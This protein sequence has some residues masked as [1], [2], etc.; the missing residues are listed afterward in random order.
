[1]RL[2]LTGFAPDLD[3]SIPG[4]LTD[5]DSIVPTTRG[6]AAGASLSPSGYPA[7]ASAPTSAFVAELLDGSKRTFAATATAIYEAVSGSWTDR[8]RVGGY[9]GTNRTR[10]CV[11]GNQVLSANRTQIINQAAPGGA[12]ADIAGAPSASI[13]V[14]AAG[15][16]MA[17]N[18]NGMTLGDAPDGWGCCAVRN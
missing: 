18:I 9:T 17:L 6:L 2:E 5:C 8:S 14:A 7:L 1:M 10:F 3:P 4:V 13:L 15:F 16:V 12:F 11:F